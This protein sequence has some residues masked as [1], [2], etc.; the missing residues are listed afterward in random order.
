MPTCFS[1]FR[2]HICH[3][4]IKKPCKNNKTA[5]SLDKEIISPYKETISSCN[6]I[7]SLY[8]KTISLYEEMIALYDKM[9]GSYDG[10]VCPYKKTVSLYDGIIC[11]YGETILLY[12]ET[13]SSYKEIISPYN[14]IVSSYKEMPDFRVFQRDRSGCAQ[15]GIPPDGNGDRKILPGSMLARKACFQN[16][17]ASDDSVMPPDRMIDGRIMAGKAAEGVQSK[18]LARKPRACQKVAGGWSAGENPR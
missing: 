8:D 6:K 4:E 9:A 11:P 16:H 7:A 12:D 10:M 18:T 5:I 2:S 1:G 3:S 17:S 15:P 14:K 13:I